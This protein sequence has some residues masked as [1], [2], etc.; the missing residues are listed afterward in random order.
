VLSLAEK[1]RKKRKL[2]PS[3]VRRPAAE[4][5]GAGSD[6]TDLSTEGIFVSHMTGMVGGR[7]EMRTEVIGAEDWCISIASPLQTRK[8]L[9]VEQSATRNLNATPSFQ[10]R[11]STTPRQ[12]C[13]CTPAE[14]LT[15]ALL[16]RT[17]SCVNRL[18]TCVANTCTD[19]RKVGIGGPVQYASLHNAHVHTHVGSRRVCLP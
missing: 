16:M 7:C 3:K 10:P 6:K 1:K 9:T 14:E 11:C 5:S 19:L 8:E 12:T 2:S 15:P 13:P 17:W 4:G 18:R